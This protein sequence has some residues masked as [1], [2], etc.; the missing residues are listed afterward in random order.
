LRRKSHDA[1]VVSGDACESKR[2]NDP[3]SSYRILMTPE[4]WKS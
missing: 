3:V 2:G 1:R 4:K